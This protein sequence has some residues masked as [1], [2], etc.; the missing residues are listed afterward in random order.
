MKILKCHKEVAKDPF[1]MELNELRP[2]FLKWEEIIRA[3]AISTLGNRD[4]INTCL[5]YMLYSVSTRK[6]FN[7]AY[8]IAKRMANISVQGTTALPYG[9]LLTR[10]FRFCEPIPPSPTLT[11]GHFQ[12]LTQSMTV[13]ILMIPF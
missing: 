5:S 1:G 2:Q 3:N 7:L 11:N 13:F 10:L 9:M 8:Y 6:T 12:L 4:H